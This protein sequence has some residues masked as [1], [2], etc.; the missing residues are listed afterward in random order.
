MKQK[1]R[2]VFLKKCSPEKA[3]ALARLNHAWHL[4]EKAAFAPSIEH[5]ITAALPDC[6]WSEILKSEWDEVKNNLKEFE[7]FFEYEMIDAAK[8]LT[9]VEMKERGYKVI[10]EEKE[11]T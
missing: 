10:Y 11:R 3:S 8:Q 5:S 9:E 7:K 6:E 1:N 4:W 2:H